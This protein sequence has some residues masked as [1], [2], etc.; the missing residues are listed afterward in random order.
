VSTRAGRGS[1]RLGMLRVEEGELLSDAKIFPGGVAVC[2]Y[3]I[4]RG[5]QTG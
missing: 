4:V 5:N 1:S 2:T 3:S